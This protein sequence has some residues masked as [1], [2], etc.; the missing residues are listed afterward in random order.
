MELLQKFSVKLCF[1]GILFGSFVFCH[2]ML[3]RVVKNKNLVKHGNFFSKS[4]DIK[5]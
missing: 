1:S 4:V 2:R 3:N 5:F